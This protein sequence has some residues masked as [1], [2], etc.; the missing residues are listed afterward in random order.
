VA[1][2]FLK[3]AGG[4]RQ[5]A[6]EVVAR[7]PRLFGRYHEPFLG[8][9]AIFFALREAGAA[10]CAFLTDANAELCECFQVVRDEV[11][12][13]VATLR[14]V[15]ESYLAEDAAGRKEFYYKQ[16]ECRPSTAVARAARMI[17]LNRTCY[18]GL[19]RV[20]RAGKFNVPHGRYRNPRILDE[21]TLRAASVALQGAEI[22]RGDF[23]EAC[24]RAERGDFVYLDPPYQ[25]LSATSQFT[26]YTAGVFG[27]AEQERL[28][29][30]FEALT[31]RG[32]AALLSN[33]DHPAIRA[34]Y[35]GQGYALE[36]VPMSRAINSV[37]TKR[38]AID[39]LLISNFG[40]PEVRAAFD[41]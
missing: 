17:F 34:L 37:V 26:S 27:P 5:L 11:S 29:D 7:A 13:L 38:G 8:G 32:V 14:E 25:P 30:E 31:R 23:G 6:S 24:R 39:E 19:Y 16:R 3:W 12:G 28:R 22:R 4:K 2:P 10:Q 40:R 36:L 1:T 20:N 35:E 21:E 41:R 33:S 18:N 15:A 9:G